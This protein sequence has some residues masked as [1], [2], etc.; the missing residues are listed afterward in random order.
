MAVNTIYLDSNIIYLGRPTPIFI[1][2]AITWCRNN[3]L[4][5]WTC[6]TTEESGQ[7]VFK[8]ET[9]ADKAAFILIWL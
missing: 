3:C 1:P 6:E 5:D 8:F 4:L 2:N 9:E 7:W